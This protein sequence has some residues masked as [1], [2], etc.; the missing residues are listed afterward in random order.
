[1]KRR[2]LKKTSKLG[3]TL[4]GA[5]ALLIVFTFIAVGPAWKAAAFTVPDNGGT[6]VS[7]QINIPDL[8]PVTSV[9][10]RLTINTPFPDDI[11]MLLVAPDG[12][13]NL[14]FMS[15]AGGTNPFVGTITFSDSGVSM[16]PDENAPPLASI[17]YLP[18]DY[19]TTEI[20][21]DWGLNIPTINHAPGNAGTGDFADFNGI[22]SAGAWTLYVRDDSGANFGTTEISSW[23]LI[24]NGTTAAEAVIGGRITTPDAVAVSGATVKLSGSQSRKTIS[25]AN[26]NYRFDNVESNG[27]YT[28]TPARTN[29][30]FSPASRNF[31][32]LGAST[33]ATF[34]AGFAG[35]S[36][37]PLDTAEYFVRQQYVD[38]LGREPDE[39]GFNY[40]SDRILDCG[41]DVLCVSA[42]RRDVAAAFFIEEEFQRRGLFIH[43]LYK[44]SLSRNPVYVEFSA[45]RQQV[46][47]GPNLEARKQAF[48]QSFVGRTEFVTKYQSNLS[49]GS[50]VDALI[51][52]VRQT[53]ALDLTDERASLIGTYNAGTTL[54]QSRAAVVRALSENT[55]FKAAEYNAAFVLAEYFG[56][57]LRD[58]DS[59]GYAFWLNVVNNRDQSNY[60]SMVCAFITSR[61]Y[62]ERFSSVVSRSDKECGQ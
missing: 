38:L 2:S 40:W 7:S 50:F 36:A 35:E 45:D 55:A 32:Q 26:G 52:N 43:A 9:A 47:E 15:D 27:F 61:E 54:E 53:S 23:A 20:A 42:R 11:D 24:I 5:L 56:Y 37:N 49:A 4:R 33:E 62:Q 28:V 16:V 14:E 21:P 46:T 6:G 44:G 3:R 31:S 25:D 48:V 59:D 13:T 39:G 12:D 41:L 17:T 34:T 8:G 58:P 57:L 51:Q 60:R 18:A 10:I 1:M 30:T 19:G 29:Y 22:D